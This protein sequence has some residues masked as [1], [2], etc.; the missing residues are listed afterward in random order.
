M[1]PGQPQLHQFNHRLQ[2]SREV[3]AEHIQIGLNRCCRFAQLLLQLLRELFQLIHTQTAREGFQRVHL[4]ER[5]RRVL[6]DK[7]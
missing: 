1:R 4:I 5:I 3:L 6:R 7:R 2:F